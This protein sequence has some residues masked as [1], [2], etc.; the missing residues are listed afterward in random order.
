MA[1][2]CESYRKKR[3]LKIAREKC[4]LGKYMVE[5]RYCTKVKVIL[6]LSD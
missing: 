5:P 6:E 1:I 3:D 2:A 4:S